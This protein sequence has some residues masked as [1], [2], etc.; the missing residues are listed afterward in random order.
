MSVTRRHFVASASAAATILSAGSAPSLADDAPPETTTVRFGKGRSSSLPRP[1]P[2]PMLP[3]REI[4]NGERAMPHQRLAALLAGIAAGIVLATAAVAAAADTAAPDIRGTW[5]LEAKAIVLGAGQHHPADP[6][7]RIEPGKPRLRK[8]AP[9]LRITGQEGERF[10]GA[11]E[12]PAYK[13]DFVGAFT[14][15]GRGFI[16]VDS[17]GFYQGNVG[18]DGVVSYCYQHTTPESRLVACGT[19]R[20]E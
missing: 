13:E 14:G 20:R 11:I 6:G 9:T 18:E 17:D 7:E 12:S 15:E 5:R 8:L 4:I 10:W 3:R 19:G 2:R 1:P 16:G